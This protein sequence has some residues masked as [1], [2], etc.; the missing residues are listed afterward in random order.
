MLD[1]VDA[2]MNSFHV[3]SLREEAHVVHE[4]IFNVLI[5]HVSDVFHLHRLLQL[6]CVK[7]WVGWREVTDILGKCCSNSLKGVIIGDCIKKFALLCQG[8]VMV[9][10][11]PKDATRRT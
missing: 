10:Q 11:Y 9:K 1:D 2:N 3:E 4:D 6:K 7:D 5:K 8:V